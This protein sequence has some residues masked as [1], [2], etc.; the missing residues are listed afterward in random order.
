MNFLLRKSSS[1]NHNSVG[2]MCLCL[3]SLLLYSAVALSQE[4]EVRIVVEKRKSEDYSV[5]AGARV[6]VVEEESGDVSVEGVETEDGDVIIEAEEVIYIDNSDSEEDETI[7]VDQIAPEEREPDQDRQNRRDREGQSEQGDRTRRR[8][9]RMF[10]PEVRKIM[11]EE[12]IKAQ[13]M[14]DPEVRKRVMEKAQLMRTGSEGDSQPDEEPGE[15]KQKEFE[16]PKIE[17]P[18]KGL[19]LYMGTIAKKNLFLPL[20]SGN[21]KRKSSFALTAVVSGSKSKAIIEETG[22]GKSFYVSEGDTFADNIEV[23]D[24]EEQLVKLDRSGEEEEIRLGAGTS[25]GRRGGGGRRGGRNTG[26]NA[27][28]RSGGGN[29]KASGVQGGG[30]SFDAS[31]IPPFAQRILKERGISIDELRRNPELRNRLRREFE[32]RFGG[33]NRAPQPVRV[34]GSGGGN[35]R[36]RN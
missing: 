11:E 24:I 14:R 29:K 36:R 19:E 20:G 7:D 18:K 25:S 22:G 31:Q 26:G 10:S 4:A 28:S 17:P 27:G 2:F 21:E 16:E 1:S 9:G 6:L 5:E 30:E 34:Q 33:S 3:V 12:G 15:E 13:D 35:R 8:Q 32:G 23:V